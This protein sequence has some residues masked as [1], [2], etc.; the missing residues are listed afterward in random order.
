MSLAYI[1]QL[2]K[3]DDFSLAIVVRKIYSKKSL[4]SW[5][6]THH[7]VTDLVNLEMVKKTKT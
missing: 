7:E 1:N 5:I 4:F 2:A 3:F 6:N